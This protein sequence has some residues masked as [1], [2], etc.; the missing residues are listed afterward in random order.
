VKQKDLV[1]NNKDEKLNTNLTIKYFLDTAFILPALELSELREIAAIRN[2]R[3]AFC[4]F[5]GPSVAK[6][7]SANSIRYLD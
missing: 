4:G 1:V 5:E 7:T 3:S 2:Q 6:E